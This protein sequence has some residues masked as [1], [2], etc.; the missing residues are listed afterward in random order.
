M[1]L[2]ENITKEK[3]KQKGHFMLIE[4][5]LDINTRTKILDYIFHVIMDLN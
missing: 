1:R 4:S 3:R 5:Q 2:L